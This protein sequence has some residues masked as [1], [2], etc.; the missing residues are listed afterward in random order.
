MASFRLLTNTLIIGEWGFLALQTVLRWPTSPGE[1]HGRGE[2]PC[3]VGQKRR[4]RF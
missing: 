3:R 4:E 1:P 2:S